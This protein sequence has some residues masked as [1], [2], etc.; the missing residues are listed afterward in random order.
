MEILLSCPAVIKGEFMNFRAIPFRIKLFLLVAIPI[1]GILIEA[2]GNISSGIANVSSAKRIDQLIEL[3]TYNSALV[4]ELQKERGLTAGYI[5]S[6]GGKFARELATQHG[7]ADKTQQ[8]KLEFLDA[9]HISDNKINNEL[10]SIKTDLDKL[11]SIRE[12]VK[13]Q[14]IPLPDAI[15]YY[16]QLNK[17]ILELTFYIVDLSPDAKLTQGAVAYNS[18]LLGKE[19]AGIERAVLS[20]AFSQKNIGEHLSKIC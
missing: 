8:N 17:K 14:S 7:A 5:G 3:S 13:T 2:V 4:H 1:I 16:T 20:G 15:S 19:R 9:I 12:K 10:S 11:S 18:F 6:K